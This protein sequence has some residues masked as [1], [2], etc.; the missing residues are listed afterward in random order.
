MGHG[1]QSNDKGAVFGTTWHDH[2]NYLQ[3]PTRPT[4]EQVKEAINY[5]VDKVPVEV[6]GVIV[7]NNF[8]LRRADDK[9]IINCRCVGKRYQPLQNAELVQ[10]LH[11]TLIVPNTGMIDYDSAGSF[12]GGKTAFVSMEVLTVKIKGDSSDTATKI[13]V[14]NEFGNVCATLCKCSQRTVCR[15]TH[16]IAQAQGIANGSFTKF[17]HHQDIKERIQGS[18]INLGQ[19]ISGME[20]YIAKLNWMAEQSMGLAEAENFIKALLPLESDTNSEAIELGKDKVLENR[21]II[22]DIFRGANFDTMTQETAQS[23][24]GMFNA[25]TYWVGHPEHKRVLRKNHNQFKSAWDNMMEGTPQDD[26]KQSAFALLT[27]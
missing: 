25:V 1:I 26:M 4:F 3:L 22:F 24:Y 2:P 12:D 8:A 9:T 16:R 21:E 7:P 14:S 19:E 15:N 10:F 23:R 17:R 20:M 18:I 11:D 6:E 27:K 13:L 5:G